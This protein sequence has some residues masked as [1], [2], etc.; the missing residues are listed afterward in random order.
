MVSKC[1]NPNCSEQFRYLHQGKLFHL[2]PVPDLEHITEETCGG[3]YERFWLCEECCKKFTV[4]WDG[5]QA[6]VVS[7]RNRP[8]RSAAAALGEHKIER[9]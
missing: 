9:T 6:Q 5:E 4:V 2:S 7:S 1:A 8:A 3:L